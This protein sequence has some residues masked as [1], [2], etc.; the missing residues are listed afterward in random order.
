MS[1]QLIEQWRREREQ[2]EARRE[3]ARLE[4]HKTKMAQ[5]KLSKRTG[6]LVVEAFQKHGNT[7]IIANEYVEYNPKENRHEILDN[8]I[9][10]PHI[11]TIA[12]ITSETERITEYV[13]MRG[14]VAVDYTIYKVVTTEGEN[15]EWK[16]DVQGF[17]WRVPY[18]FIIEPSASCTSMAGGSSLKFRF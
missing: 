16:P 18:W 15:I 6:G 10:S 9:A 14:M 3:A 1:S 7:R 17:N 13:H 11:K 12:S 2:E 5:L 8:T 4:L